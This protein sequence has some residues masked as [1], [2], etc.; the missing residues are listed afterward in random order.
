MSIQV[1]ILISKPN[2]KNP[3]ITLTQPQSQ[4]SNY[5]QSMYEALNLLQSPKPI[6]LPSSD[7]SNTSDEVLLTHLPAPPIPPNPTNY[8][9][10]TQRHHTS[11]SHTKISTTPNSRRAS[12]RTKR[13]D[14]YSASADQ[15]KDLQD[16]RPGRWAAAAASKHPFSS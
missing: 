9:M 2:L 1:L 16:N 13:R 12:D 11:L 15:I 8:I 4:P 7:T 6:S 3:I 14:Q 10:A 5:R